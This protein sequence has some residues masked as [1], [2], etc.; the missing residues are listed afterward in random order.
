M[1]YNLGI[2][3]GDPEKE[4]NQPISMRLTQQACWW[5]LILIAMNVLRHLSFQISQALGS[6]LK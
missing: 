5:G 4:E 1:L 6:S 2:G 3:L